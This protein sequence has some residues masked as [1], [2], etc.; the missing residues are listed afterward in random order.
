M[1]NQDLLRV[2]P[3]A[4]SDSCR[5]FLV[6]LDSHSEPVQLEMLILLMNRLQEAWYPDTARPR[7]VLKLAADSLAFLN[8]CALVLQQFQS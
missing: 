5:S 4:N 2:T 6:Q 7:P 3:L 1:A 8:Q